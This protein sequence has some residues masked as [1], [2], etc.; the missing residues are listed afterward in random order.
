MG[1]HWLGLGTI[2]FR[3]LPQHHTP[4]LAPR[5]CIVVRILATR[6]PPA[7]KTIPP[8]HKS[9]KLRDD[10]S[11]SAKR[12]LCAWEKFRPLHNTLHRL[13]PQDDV[14]SSAKRSY[15][16]VQ[17][18]ES[19]NLATIYSRSLKTRRRMPKFASPKPATTY[20]RPP[21]LFGTSWNWPH[22]VTFFGRSF[23]CVTIAKVSR[24]LQ[25]P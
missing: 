19:S 23:T 7:S 16:T 21:N 9:P 10:V 2:S 13:W 14:S 5:Q 8:R 11:T 3:I 25:R 18:Q 24:H 15:A 4:L 6:H 20:R 17:L 1:W 12:P 22:V